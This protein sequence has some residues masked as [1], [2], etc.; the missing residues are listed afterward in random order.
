MYVCV[1]VIHLN[2]G[3]CSGPRASDLKLELQEVLSCLVC[4]LGIKPNSTEIRLIFLISGIS[5]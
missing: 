1:P 3:A 4:V 2:I 5:P